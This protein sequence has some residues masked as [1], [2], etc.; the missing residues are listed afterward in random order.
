MGKIIERSNSISIIKLSKN[1]KYLTYK[2]LLEL[3]KYSLYN[4]VKLLLIEKILNQ[5]L[6]MN[7]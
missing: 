2:E 5:K 1:Y 3:Y 7:I 6:N 4:N